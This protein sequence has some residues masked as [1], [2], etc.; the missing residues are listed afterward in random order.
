V[1]LAQRSTGNLPLPLS[2]L[3]GRQQEQADVAGLLE[4]ARLVSLV[5]IGGCGKTRLAQAVAAAASDAFADG[6]WWVELGPLTGPGLVSAV[7][8]AAIEAPQAPGEEP[9][10]S[11]VRHLRRQQA[12]LVLDNCEHVVDEAAAVAEHLLRSCPQVRVLATSREVL[13]VAGEQVVRLGGLDTASAGT[14]DAVSLFVERA[15]SVVAGYNPEPDELE[16]VHHLCVQLDGLPLGIELA[17]ARVSVLPVGEIAARLGGNAPL[18]RHPNRSAPR[19]HQTLE[20]ALDWSHRLLEPHE[21]V[22][23]RR[24]AA[25]SGTFSL[26]AAESVASRPPIRSADVLGV[27]SGLVDKSLVQVAD[28]GAEHRYSLLETVHH[29]ASSRLAESA[30]LAA[31][32]A[33]H[34]DFYLGLARQ[35]HAGLEG[36]DQAQWLARLDLEHD[37]LRSV[38]RRHLPS[39]PE[40][41]GSLAA[42][43]WPFWY[44][45]GYYHEA[46][47]WLEQAVAAAGSM[48]PAVAAE[49]LTGAGVLAFLQCDYLLATEQ[50]GRALELHH[51]LGH[52]VGVATVKQRLG[53]IAREQGRYDD[54][55]RLHLSAR[56][57]W[58]ALGDDA[59]VA[60]SDD[61]LCF[62]AWLEGDHTQAEARGRAALAYFEAA[63]R[64]QETAAALVNLGAAAQL[65]GDDQLA[66]ERLHRALGLSRQLGY[67]EG[68]AW[69]LHLLGTIEPDPAASATLLCES[70][71]V[72][73]QL[74]DRWRV[75]SVLESVA[76][77]VLAPL[78]P[79]QAACL[80][81]AADALRASLATPVPPA[82]RSLLERARDDARRALGAAAFDGAW[83]AG[84]SLTFDQA[85]ELADGACRS[86]RPHGGEVRP[87]SGQGTPADE[88]TDREVEVLRLIGRGLTNRQ[89]GEALFISAGTAGVHVSNILRKLGVSSRVQ[90]AALAQRFGLGD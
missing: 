77:R 8:A 68:T 2:S 39:Q 83:N 53:S 80:L 41:G 72:H 47:A 37:N 7:A 84:H 5:G 82:E 9:L 51:Q 87:G 28:R 74:G 12:L 69:S 76:C 25:F 38:L 13:G 32:E 46:R 63:G 57:L 81:G 11:L 35:A 16:R 48:S 34:A 15:R 85:T 66:T 23:F 65:A 79:G 17:A 88:L 71:A 90:A 10:P 54:A 27:L 62:V 44:R 59:G 43:L 61:Y 6:V 50:L 36:P 21:Q 58:S 55:R 49:S 78:D 73:R 86:V 60:A 1:E 3:V 56:D 52:R 40:V 29:Y 64:Q 45:K 42:L 31:T 70:L 19:R 20:D 33:A 67:L 14:G 4:R 75:A 18:L 89:I 26:L 22:L 24:L 30:D